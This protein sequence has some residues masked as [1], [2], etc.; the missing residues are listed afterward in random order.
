V[1]SLIETTSTL[2][3]HLAHEPH[4]TLLGKARA[5]RARMAGPLR[6][7]LGGA[8]VAG[9]GLLAIF[10]IVFYY[11][12]KL[13]RWLN[14]ICSRTLDRGIDRYYSPTL[15][16]VL[17][18]PAL[19]ICGGVAF[20]LVTAGLFRGGY[21]RWQFFPDLDSTRIQATVIYP[22]GTP[23]QVTARAVARVSAALDEVDRRLAK[24]GVRPV[25]V[26]KESV[27][28]L[29]AQNSVDQRSQSTGS[30]LG[31]VE[32]ELTDSSLRDIK[33]QAIV[34]LWREAAGEFAGAES[35][36]FES[37]SFGPAGKKIE[38][39]LLADRA[40]ADELERA[41]D[42]AKAAL[43]SYAGVFDADDD[44][45]PGKAELR[46][47]LKPTAVALGVKR[48]DLF[49][50]VRAAYF[51][52]EVM[53][54]QRG[55]HEI[56]IMARLPEADRRSF[57]DWEDLR[58]RTSDPSSPGTMIERPITELAAV[59]IG[60]GPSEINR[61]DRMR[62]ITVYSDLDEAVAGATDVVTSLS[63]RDPMPPWM[64]SLATALGAPPF[65]PA[66]N[67]LPVAL[68]DFPHVR[69][70]W[71][72]QAEQQSESIT[73]MLMGMACAIVGMFALLT[74]EFKSYLQPL[75]I[76][77]IIPFGLA[78]AVLGHGVMGLPVS[79]FSMMGMVALTG[80]VVND[81]IVLVDF[82]NL[83]L[84]E[85]LTLNE[86]LYEAGVR[87]LRPVVLNSVTSCVGLV[88]MLFEK[89]FQAQVLIPMGAAIF[90]GL[91]TTTVLVLVLLP[92]VY[93]AYGSL[94]GLH[95]TPGGG[96][97]HGHGE[98]DTGDE[99]YVPIRPEPVGAG[100]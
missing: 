38:F 80:I 81:S 25:K 41:A 48:A 74:I 53:R 77:M 44:H 75:L 63:G 66:A 69:V 31:Q 68:K 32:A 62:S 72:G 56:K 30:H 100:A 58:V 6:W 24:D 28:Y 55:R 60:S 57:A 97:R 61:V 49:E 78:G 9:A 22:D 18:R 54:V 29:G 13:L 91:T 37:P 71:K 33:S 2:P 52:E 76:L 36:T 7:T 46:V 12:A 98:D 40:H 43:A 82:V 65:V 10:G 11:P 14:P 87:R 16:W 88:P 84:G 17:R 8:L 3:M 51:G 96:R 89:S 83:K 50:T 92:A 23:E 95:D 34:A 64:R 99:S 79:F 93:S 70:L 73:S 42:A 85:G 19:T 94:V 47:D 5:A 90:F 1:I 67:S 26:R 27:G 21:I 45:R 59:S 20:L 4:G 15:R 86:A 39:K 35:V